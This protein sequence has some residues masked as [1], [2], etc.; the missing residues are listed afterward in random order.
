MT[1]TA[2]ALGAVIRLL[3]EV[4]IIIVGTQRSI[5]VTSINVLER[6]SI[7]FANLQ[8]VK[9]ENLKNAIGLSNLKIATKLGQ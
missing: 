6:E 5:Y 4:L 1:R 7:I 3:D 9:T 8:I 2:L